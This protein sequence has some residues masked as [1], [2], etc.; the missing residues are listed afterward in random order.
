MRKTTIIL[1]ALCGLAAHIS[2]ASAAPTWC[3]G[4]DEKPSYDVK[5]LFSETDADR[6]LMQLVAASCY[7]E[8][9]VAQMSKQVNATREAWNKK[10]GM[11]EA[12]WADVSEWA[13]LPRHLRGDPKIEVK[14][15]QGGVVRVL[16]ARSVRRADHPTWASSTTRTSRTRSARSSPS[17]DGWATSRTAS[18]LTRSI[19]R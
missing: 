8:A 3:K 4:G 12:D 5:S 18:A 10:L 11:V 13:H 1:T 6:A 2:T 15:R 17:S 7:G 16:A 14:D 9:D 19:R